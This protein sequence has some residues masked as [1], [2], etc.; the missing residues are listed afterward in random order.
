MIISRIDFT[1]AI[2]DQAGAQNGMMSE[3]PPDIFHRTLQ[4]VKLFPVPPRKHGHLLI[5]AQRFPGRVFVVDSESV[6]IGERILVEYAL[7]IRDTAE[8]AEALAAFREQHALACPPPGPSAVRRSDEEYH[9][10]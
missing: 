9:A 7:R 10:R 4:I 2:R 5:A 3:A 6:S 1:N 8:S